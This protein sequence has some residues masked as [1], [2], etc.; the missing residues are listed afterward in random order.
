MDY[1]KIAKAELRDVPAMRTA[2]DNIK[3]RIRSLEMQKTSLRSTSDSTPVQGGGNRQEDRLLNL[4][5]E[6]ERLRLSLT[7][8]ELCMEVIERGLAALSDQDRLLLETF[9]R[10]RSGEA[11]NILSDTLF[12]ERTRVYQ[13]WD[14]AL[15]R[16]T[17]AEFGLVDF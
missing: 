3:D 13:L 15:R 12:L 9:A 10:N 7:A 4:I 14:E 1:K 11:V 2:M 6:S 17:I 5:V 8:H 16:Y